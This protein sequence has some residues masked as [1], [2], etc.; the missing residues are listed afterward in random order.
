MKETAELLYNTV[1]KKAVDA[2]LKEA[3]ISKPITA[4]TN[5]LLFKVLVVLINAHLANIGKP[6]RYAD[7]A[8]NGLRA[9]NSP[10]IDVPND[11]DSGA[12]FEVI[13]STK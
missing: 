4:L 1:A 8:K 13:P 12:I 6:G 7:G 5:D 2:A 3:A 10:E 11:T 9:A